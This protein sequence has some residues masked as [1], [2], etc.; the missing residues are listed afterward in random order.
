MIAQ[1]SYIQSLHDITDK[2]DTY[3]ID[4]VGVLCDGKNKFDHAIEIINTLLEQQKQIIFLSNNPYPSTVL[5]NKLTAYGIHD[6]YYAI[7]SGDV[8][9]HTIKT[10]FTNK[11]IYH[12]GRNRQ[13]T[14]L[15]NTSANLTSC[16]SDAEI[17]IVSCFVEENEDHSIYDQDLEKI[18]ASGKTVY[19]PNPDQVAFEGNILRYPSGYFAHK[20]QQKGV[21]I[22]YLGKPSRIIY[23]FIG[24]THPHVSL[25]PEKTLMIGDTLETDIYGARNFGIDS[26]LVLNGITGLHM[27][28]NPHIITQSLHQPTYV[29]EKLA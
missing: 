14:I 5:K 15:E 29:I 9:H 1:P 7:T 16:L 23:E 4:V 21:T 2:Y 28:D 24:Y 18:V 20:L 22:T 27:Q 13:H 19:C 3:L 11:K 10:T 12:L 25:V 6:N 8:L 17:V 26:L